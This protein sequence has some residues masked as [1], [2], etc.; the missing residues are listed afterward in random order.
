VIVGAVTTE[1]EPIVTLTVAGQPW[2]ATIDTGF[3]GDLELPDQLRPFL[4]ARFLCRVVSFLAGGQSVEE[5][6]YEVD[7]PFDGQ[8][9]VA[10][11][12]FVPGDGILIGTHLLRNDRLE[13][14]FVDQTVLLERMA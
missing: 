4:N 14:S 10:V 11:A 6:T 9:V 1:G 3:N 13:I 2:S 8:T 5:D 12:T 7:L